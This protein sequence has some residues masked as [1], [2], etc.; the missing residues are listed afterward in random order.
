MASMK[1]LQRY[2]DQY[3]IYGPEGD[4]ETDL[5]ELTN[6][7]NLQSSPTAHECDVCL[8]VFSNT[9][10]L[11][12]HAAFWHEDRQKHDTSKEVTAQIKK[13]QLAS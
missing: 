10:D 11:F 8:R 5:G 1:L 2:K 7:D 3:T 13:P 6:L 12:L 9:D 4:V